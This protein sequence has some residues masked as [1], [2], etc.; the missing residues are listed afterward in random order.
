MV[1]ATMLAKA[2]KDRDECYLEATDTAKPLYEKH[3]FVAVNELRFDPAEYGVHGYRIER[4][5]IMVRGA[6]DA[7]GV[8]QKVRPWPMATPPTTPPAEE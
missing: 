1:L 5:T 4:Q 3:G 8:R 2:D 7:Y 6:L